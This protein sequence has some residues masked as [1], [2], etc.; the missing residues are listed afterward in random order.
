MTSR[1]IVDTARK[2]NT[3]RCKCGVIAE[4]RASGEGREMI[5]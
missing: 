2:K 4:E 5:G 3:E 1:K